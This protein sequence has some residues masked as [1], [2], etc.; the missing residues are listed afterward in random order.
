LSPANVK[1][2]KTFTACDTGDLIRLQAGYSAMGKTKEAR[3]GR[4][5][6][7]LLKLTSNRE[8]EVLLVPSPF[9]GRRSASGDD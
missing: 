5:C 9:A 2:E 8:E 6:A 7:G 4:R 1:V 3:R